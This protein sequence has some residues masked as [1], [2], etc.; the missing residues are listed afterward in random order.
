[1]TRNSKRFQNKQTSIATWALEGLCLR[2]SKISDPLDDGSQ[3]LTALIISYLKS[4][5]KWFEIHRA[6]YCTEGNEVKSKPYTTFIKEGK[7]KRVGPEE[8]MLLCPCLLNN[9]KMEAVEK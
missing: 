7:H 2:S 5:P 9:E 3:F 4:G 1:M 6:I 8:I